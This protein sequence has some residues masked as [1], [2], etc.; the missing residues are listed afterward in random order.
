MTD[1]F[2]TISNGDRV[3]P[4]DGI[5][6]KRGEPTAEDFILVPAAGTVSATVELSEAYSISTRGNYTVQLETTI[7]YYSISG[8]ASYHE[9]LASHKMTFRMVGNGKARPTLGER[10]RLESLASPQLTSPVC[11]GGNFYERKMCRSV[12]WLVHR[13]LYSSYIAAFNKPYLYREWFGDPACCQ[14]NVTNTLALMYNTMNKETIIYYMHGPRCKP[15]VFA[16]TFKDSRGIYYCDMFW[17][18]KLVY[19]PH[20]SKISTCIHGLSHA[21]A[22][23]DNLAYG[24]ANCKNLA[25]NHPERAVR[26][27]DNYGY[28]AE[29]Q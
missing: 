4:Y 3:I 24:V 11:I 23:T 29:V 2:L 22:S 28:F 15:N 17:Q 18:S 5:F 20:D 14:N 13:K 27:A 26:N 19:P 6:V 12:H 21:I 25:K 10:A 9:V 8:S 7:E 1:D 16:Y